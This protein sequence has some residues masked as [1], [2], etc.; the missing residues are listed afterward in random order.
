MAELAKF[1]GSTR[2]CRARRDL[3]GHDLDEQGE[4][5]KAPQDDL[6]EGGTAIRIGSG[7]RVLVL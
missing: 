5:L 2:G 4:M 3:E 7:S 1:E 6:N